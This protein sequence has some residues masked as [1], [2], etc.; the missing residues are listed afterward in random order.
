MASEVIGRCTCPVC[1]SDRARLTL[2]RSMLS[3]L[4]CNSCNLQVFSR[5]DRSDSLLRGLL[6]TEPAAAA[7]APAEPAPP[8]K[9]SPDPAPAP[10]PAA[11][12]APRRGW[13][14]LG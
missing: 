4:T 13:G 5:S 1:R 2:A 6:I 3:V 7:P 8:P 9:A 12:A 10:A 14:F 11:D